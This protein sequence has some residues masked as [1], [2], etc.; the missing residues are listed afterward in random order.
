MALT[1]EPLCSTPPTLTPCS[2]E[3]GQIRMDKDLDMAQD[4]FPTEEPSPHGLDAPI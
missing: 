2:S 3:L 1:L 4:P